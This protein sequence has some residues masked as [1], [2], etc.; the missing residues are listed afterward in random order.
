MKKILIVLA[1]MFASVFSADAQKWSISTNVIDWANLGTINGEVGVAVSQ[2][3]SLMAGARYNP[4]TFNAGDQQ[5]QFQNRKQSYHIGAR[6]WP[7]HIYSGWWFSGQAQYQEYNRGGILS[8]DT[9]EGDAVGLGLSFGYTLMLHKNLNIEFGAGAWG[10]HK[11]YTAFKCPICGRI[12]EQ[13]HKW[14]V[15]PN[16]VKVS[17]MYIF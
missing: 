8:R 15:M 1:V 17:L 4:W 14:F 7:W 3:W 2:H 10:G 5:R 13:G 12:V 6:V 11:W 16:E 9:E